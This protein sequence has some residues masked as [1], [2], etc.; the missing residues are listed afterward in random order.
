MIFMTYRKLAI[1]I[2]I[3][4][5]LFAAV[6]AHA[7]D[8]C[9]AELAR[10]CSD[11][12][13]DLTKS[14]CLASHKDELS[15]ECKKELVR[16]NQLVKDT[17]ARGAGLS[18]YGGVMGGLG[19]I[20][21]QKSVVTFEGAYAWEGNPTVVNQGKIGLNSP[22][23]KK[24]GSSFTSSLSAGTIQF[25]EAVS[26]PKGDAISELHRVEAG[27]QY[28]KITEEKKSIGLRG[29]FGSA[30][31]KPFAS[32]REFIFSVNGFYAPTPKSD[33]SMW[34]YT[35]FLS[36][37][38]PL[39]NYVPIPG[40]IYFM[41]K[42]E[43]T[44]MF[45]LPFMS[46]QWTPFKK[47]LFSGSFFIT[48]FKASAIYLLQDSTQF[49]FNFANIQ[50]TFLR[51]DRTNFRDRLFF[52]ERRLY[53]HARQVL[54]P[55]LVLELQSGIS[56]DRNLREGKSFTQKNWE[57]DLGRSWFVGTNLIVSFD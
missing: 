10:F 40:F 47:W 45:G 42:N 6:A 2:S 44:G 27:G 48:N 15:T 25:N 41:K 49:G 22:L 51:E 57:Q 23:W 9:S 8:P 52:N 20:P 32:S 21:P 11:Q 38:T 7:E 12:K 56:F 28:S 26:V 13:T 1:I 5:C 18:S 46:V 43:F 29:T 31:D 53:A 14:A 3:S 36:N 30:G 33:D 24:D 35:V 4:S 54:S 19:L 37:N 39:L 50:Q 55:D 17:G 34:V 16:L